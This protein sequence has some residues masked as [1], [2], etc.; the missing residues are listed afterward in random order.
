MTPKTSW[1]A[2]GHHQVDVGDDLVDPGA[3]GVGHELDLLF[4]DA[5]VEA[6]ELARLL[7]DLLGEPAEAHV[8]ERDVG[9]LVERPVGPLLQGDALDPPGHPRQGQGEHPAEV[10]GVEPGAVDGRA[11]PGAG[12]EQSV[13]V[14]RGKRLRVEAEGGGDHVLPA[15]QDGAHVVERGVAG[16][17]GDAVG[18]EGQQAGDVTGGGDAD[19]LAAGEHPEVGSVL[20]RGVDPPA[21][22]LEVRPID[23]GADRLDPLRP[24][25]PLDHSVRHRSPVLADGRPL[26]PM[27]RGPAPAPGPG[28]EAPV[29]SVP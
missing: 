6:Q 17:V 24:G 4:E 18:V 3:E 5:A 27:V 7:V 19:R 23:D 12:L 22:E 25:R 15:G 21:H 16:H 8:V 14:G 26:R 20:G 29:V 2:L 9:A 28:R 11:A 13:Q 1:S 10:A